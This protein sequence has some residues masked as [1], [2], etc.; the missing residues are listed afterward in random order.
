MSACAPLTCGSR[1]A[2]PAA[3]SDRMSAPAHPAVLDLIG[4]APLVPVTRFDTGP[5]PL[6]LKLESQNPGG[7]IKD[8]IGVAMIEAAER[9][10]RLQPGGTVVEATR[11]HSAPRSMAPAATSARATPTPTRTS[12]RAWHATSPARSSPTSSTTPPTRSR[13]RPEPAPRSGPDRPRPRRDCRRRRLGR[14]DH[15]PDALLLQGA[16]EA[17][18]RA[19]RPG[20]LDPGR[21]R[22]PRHHRRGGL[23]GR[24]RHRRRLRARHRRPERR[25]HRVLD[26]RQRDLRAIAESSPRSTTPSRARSIGGRWNSA[27]T[28]SCTRPPST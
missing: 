5:C 27:S 16:A 14:H 11:Q 10:G 20:R 22:A 9:D 2:P 3:Y 8:S 4:N 13:T 1:A 15:R 26:L 23:V 19:R 7:S 12:P 24:R 28:S 6:L 25:D 18:L 21:V 17:R